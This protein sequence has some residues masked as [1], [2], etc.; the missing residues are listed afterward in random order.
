MKKGID[1]PLVPIIFSL[2]GG[3]GFVSVAVSREWVNL[4]FPVVLLAFA[5]VYIRTSLWGKYQI[6]KQLTL[7]M[8]LA[9]NSQVLDLGTG[10]GAFLLEIASQ[11]KA[12][13]KV[14][15]LDIWNQGDQSRN[16]ATATQKNIDQAGVQTVSELVTGDM[17]K[18]AFEDNFF[19]AVVASLSIHN[20]KPKSKRQ[21]AI[22]EA[23]RVLKPAGQLVI[24]D[25]EHVAEYRQTLIQLGAREAQLHHAGINGMYGAMGTRILVAKK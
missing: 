18:L 21:Q 3:L 16:S 7:K 20:V 2:L 13:G 24:M 25:I 4:I 1:A 8:N 10:H 22:R 19:D 23:Y 14:I 12:P 17:T 11:L 5:G 6:I 15:G 9:S